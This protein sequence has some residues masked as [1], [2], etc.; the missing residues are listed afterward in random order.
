MA[1]KK[2]EGYIKLQIEAGKAN[3]SP[4][5]GPALGQHGVNIMAF[6][7]QFN[8]A[9]KK[10]VGDKLPTIITVYSD[11]SFTFVTKCP[12]VSFLIKK[13]L[14]IKKASKAPGT[15]IVAT[16]TKEQ[17]EEVAKMKMPD[18]NAY[19]IKEAMRIVEGSA[20]SMGIKVA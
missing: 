11:R 13:L 15:D 14:N 4:P 9:T 20:R 16:I 19:E 2:I 1:T 10:Q 12:P 5:I 6:C 17:V 18:L 8:D 7:K 3:P